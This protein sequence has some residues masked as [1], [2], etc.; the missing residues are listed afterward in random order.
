MNIEALEEELQ[1]TAEQV[2]LLKMQKSQTPTPRL[3]MSS[4]GTSNKVVVSKR[5]GGADNVSI[6]SASD[7]SYIV[8]SDDDD[9]DSDDTDA[10]EDEQLL[11]Y[12]KE[13]YLKMKS[14]AS[15]LIVKPFLIG[16]SV[17]LGMSFGYGI[18]DFL[19]SF[20]KRN[21]NSNK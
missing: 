2:K 13:A 20:L 21:N 17:A 19:A 8:D 7:R 18:Y 12:R 10:E 4:S 14:S 5:G 3:A 9:D 16:M 1:N 15:N 6:G 11:Q